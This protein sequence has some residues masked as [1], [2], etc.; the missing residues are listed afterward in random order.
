MRIYYTV[1][2]IRI[3]VVVGLLYINLDFLLSEVC[4]FFAVVNCSPKSEKVTESGI[5]IVPE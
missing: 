4:E 5:S 2:R 1:L 3:Y